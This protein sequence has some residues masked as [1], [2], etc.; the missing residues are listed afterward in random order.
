MLTLLITVGAYSLVVVQVDDLR[1]NLKTINCAAREV[2]L[3][4]VVF[5]SV[6]MTYACP[7]S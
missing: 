3:K 1:N 4:L 7:I 6:Y 5:K 2:P